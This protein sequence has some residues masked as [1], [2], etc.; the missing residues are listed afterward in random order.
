M[1]L[2]NQLLTGPQDQVRRGRMQLGNQLLTGP[3][4]QARPLHLIHEGA[5]SPFCLT[6]SFC[7]IMGTLT[8]CDTPASCGMRPGPYPA[9][10]G[11]PA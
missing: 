9:R 7:P 8:R 11:G 10:G 6:P 1:R 3:Q 2:G 5:S 4:D